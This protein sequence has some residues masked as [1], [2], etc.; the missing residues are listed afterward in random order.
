[1]YPL[2]LR[3]WSCAILVYVVCIDVGL[4]SMSSGGIELNCFNCTARDSAV[5]SL[6]RAGVTTLLEEFEGGRAAFCTAGPNTWLNRAW[7]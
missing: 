6:D 4:M 3:L 7:L 1:M 2:R 5:M